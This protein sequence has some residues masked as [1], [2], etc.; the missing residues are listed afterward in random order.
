MGESKPISPA[1]IAAV[2]KQRF[3]SPHRPVPRVL[4]V[5]LTFGLWCA[6]WS[7]GVEPL[8]FGSG[9]RWPTQ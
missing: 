6:Q 5:V 2:R 3:L 9:G 1:R 4:S 7:T 8:I